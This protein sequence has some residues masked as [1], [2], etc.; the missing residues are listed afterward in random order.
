MKNYENKINEVDKIIEDIQKDIISNE[1][2]E[3]ELKNFLDK[4]IGKVG[5]FENARSF[6]ANY[7]ESISK[8]LSTYATMPLERSKMRKLIID[9]SFRKIDLLAKLEMEEKVEDKQFNIYDIMN[10][11]NVAPNYDID[12]ENFEEVIEK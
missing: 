5:N 10:Q 9:S 12:N 3:D 8:L 6:S 4:V 1:E 7:I 2:R 11:L